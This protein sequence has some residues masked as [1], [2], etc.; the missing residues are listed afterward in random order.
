MNNKGK[1]TNNN[2]K[3]DILI[4]AMIIIAVALGVAAFFIIK[5]KDKLFV[6]EALC[7]TDHFMRRRMR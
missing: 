4:Y 6:K 5:N 7:S 2:K 3:M 1:K